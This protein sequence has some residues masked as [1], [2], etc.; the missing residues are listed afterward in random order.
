M[1]LVS[2]EALA[3]KKNEKKVCGGFGP[4]SCLWSAHD[5]RTLVFFFVKTSLDYVKPLNV[6]FDFDL[7]FKGPQIPCIGLRP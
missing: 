1:C 5:A 3:T 6:V 7:Y 4:G 2:G